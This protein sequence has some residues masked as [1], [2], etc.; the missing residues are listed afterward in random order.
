MNGIRQSGVGCAHNAPAS[1]LATAAVFTLLLV[2]ADLQAQ[3]FQREV[4]R[5]GTINEDLFEGARR[6]TIRAAVNGDIMAM[7]GEV[8]IDATVDGD[9]L[10]MGGDLRVGNNIKGDVLAAGGQVRAEGVI[11]GDVTV[12]A[13]MLRSITIARAMFLSSAH[14]FAHAARSAVISKCWVASW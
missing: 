3:D 11:D 8:I 9:V 5:T 7:G 10:V 13:A 6:I 4:I 1:L 14:R 12:W 2:T